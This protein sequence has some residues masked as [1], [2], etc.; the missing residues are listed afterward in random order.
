MRRGRAAV[1]FDVVVVCNN[2]LKAAFGGVETHKIARP[3]LSQ[4]DS[5]TPLAVEVAAT[6]ASNHYKRGESEE[7]T[8][9][10]V[11]WEDGIQFSFLGASSELVP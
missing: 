1:T 6:H 9:I 3:F 5:V 4:T 11:P 8:S 2:I 10:H 7:A